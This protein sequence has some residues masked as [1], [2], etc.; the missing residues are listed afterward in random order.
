MT[1]IINATGI[2]LILFIIYWF[3]VAKP[4]TAVHATDQ[5]IIDIVV[6]DGVFNPEHIK[7]RIGCPITL[8]FLRKSPN[9]CA[10]TLLFPDFAQSLDLTLG[11]TNS[12]TL[13][14]KQLGKYR[15]T[16]QMGMYQGYITVVD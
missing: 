12:I 8:R 1:L 6:D 13:T 4:K 9:H 5:G 3:W 16:C 10:D 14:P 11:E 7:A 15:F 2:G